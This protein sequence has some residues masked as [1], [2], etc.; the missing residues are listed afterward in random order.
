MISMPAE[1][2]DLFERGRTDANMTKSAYIRL[3][4]SEHENRTP[5]FWKNKDLISA[6]SDLNNKIKFLLLSGKLSDQE[7]LHLH[8]KMDELNGLLRKKLQ[9]E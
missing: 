1:Y 2:V 6:M 4:I 3:L 9:K 7:I 5:D 8:E